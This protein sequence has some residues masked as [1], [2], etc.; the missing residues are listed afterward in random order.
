VSY[1]VETSPA[2]PVDIDAIVREWLN[3]CG[4]CDGGLPMGCNCPNG[5]PRSV[6]ADLVDE[7][8]RLRK[9]GGDT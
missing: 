4:H 3:P 1:D 9:R 2:A 8:H 6:I 5:D 7:V